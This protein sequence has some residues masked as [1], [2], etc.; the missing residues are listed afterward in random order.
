MEN[1]TATAPLLRTCR[2]GCD[3]DLCESP[4]PD[5]TV[6]SWVGVRET[7]SGDKVEF[8]L[9]G[10]GGA[11]AHQILTPADAAELVKRLQNALDDIRAHASVSL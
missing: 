11:R 2:Y 3:C 1:N 7:I 6:V 5:H 9:R 4:L 8:T 10:S